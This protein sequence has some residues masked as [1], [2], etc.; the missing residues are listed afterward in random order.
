MIQTIT[1]KT[2]GYKIKATLFPSYKG[3]KRILRIYIESRVGNIL[4]A[5]SLKSDLNPIKIDKEWAGKYLLD[6]LSQKG[7]INVKEKTS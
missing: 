4:K 6:F 3:S 1:A 5:D 7:Y 2:N